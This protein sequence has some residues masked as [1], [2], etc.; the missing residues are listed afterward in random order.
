MKLKAKATLTRDLKDCRAQ[1]AERR[2]KEDGER[3]EPQKDGVAVEEAQHA[4]EPVLAQIAD[5]KVKEEID[6]EAD[7]VMLDRDPPAD[8]NVGNVHSA[9]PIPENQQ[10]SSNVMEDKA[11]SEQARQAEQNIAT[12][13]TSQ[14]DEM[15]FEL[16]SAPTN[17]RAA[18]T[19]ETTQGISTEVQVAAP[20]APQATQPNLETTGATG[21]NQNQRDLNSLLPGLESYANAGSSAN[22]L[23]NLDAGTDNEGI[24]MTATTQ[25]ADNPIT[26][27]PPTTQ[28]QPTTTIS[29]VSVEVGST[30]NPPTA[31][32]EA[33]APPPA[34]T[35][36]KTNTVNIDLTSPTDLDD[37]FLPSATTKSPP[38]I[39]AT[40]VN[41]PMNT[42]TATTSVATTAPAANP[43]P[44]GPTTAETTA[45]VTD[46]TIGDGT[47]FGQESSQFVDDLFD[48]SIDDVVDSTNPTLDSGIEMTTSGIGIGAVP[49][50]GPPGIAIGGFDGTMDL[51][52]TGD[53]GSHD[54]GFDL[55]GLMAGSDFS[56]GS[57]LANAPSGVGIGVAG[58]NS[59]SGNQDEHGTEPE[60]GDFAASFFD[61]QDS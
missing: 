11:N 27:V 6:Q 39:T 44:A 58:G 14:G 42:T 26:A 10:E 52:G 30:A 3:Q 45:P 37:L 8:I 49:S 16:I 5:S 48:F 7:V 35:A 2:R 20:Q 47:D 36:E 50:S 28:P 55:E 18:V 40:S 31:A 24:S 4:E 17:E 33:E 23:M 25:P 29:T 21:N 38:A 12:K 57:N 59:S 46:M 15:D 54:L 32:G 61:L 22:E 1:E 51:P 34:P 19:Q 9:P 56:R 43:V 13:E 60:G 53:E 41:P